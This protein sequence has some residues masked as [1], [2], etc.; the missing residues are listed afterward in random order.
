MITGML[1][2]DN[3]QKTSLANKID[4]AAQ[5]YKKK[6]GQSPEIC[7][8]HPKMIETASDSKDLS[9]MEVKASDMV[10][11]HHFWIG[12]REIEKSGV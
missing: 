11:L 6:Y 3:D 9:V 5:Y 2:F 8:V 7:F 12:R 1:W 4:R 10:L